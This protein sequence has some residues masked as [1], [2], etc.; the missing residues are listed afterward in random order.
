L[1]LATA[2]P[3]KA[4]VLSY[5]LMGSML[6]D[7]VDKPMGLLIFGTPAMGRTVCH[8]LLFL[9][10]LSAVVYYR[11]DSRLASLAGGVAAHLMLDS[12]WS[13]PGI[14]LWPLL[15]PFPRAPDLTTLDY[16][17]QLLRGLSDPMVGL[18]EMLGVAYL[19]CFSWQQRAEISC[20]TLRHVRLPAAEAR[21]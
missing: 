15:G 9:I 11:Q 2:R 6:S 20:W 1:T 13:S 7:I 17:Q 14:F 19:I 18:P 5:V 10:A 16:L 8:T 4:A 21:Q 12:I 3:F